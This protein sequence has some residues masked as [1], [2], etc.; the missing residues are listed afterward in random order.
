[1]THHSNWLFLRGLA[2]DKRHWGQ[3]GE[4]FS[5]RINGAKVFMLDLPG[6]GTERHRSAPLT[7]SETKNDLRNRWR[8]LQTQHEGAWNL[9]SLS[10]GGMVAMEWCGSHPYD[11]QKLVLLNTS[12]GRSLWKLPKRLKPGVWKNIIEVAITKS[13]RSKEAC[14]LGINSNHGPQRNPEL[15]E[16]WTQYSS[17]APNSP[18]NNF[19]QIV[20]AMNYNPPEKIHPQTLVVGSMAD[21]MVDVSCSWEL[22]QRYDTQ[23]VLHDTAGHD[24]P[25][26]VPEWLVDHIELWLRGH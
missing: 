23:L 11:F 25:M 9:L 15:Y 16:Q 8:H 5:E 13:P 24:L 22:A 6:M 26:D 3:F 10:L 2:R 17:E 20:A 21:R 7:I 18:V 19:R 14:I 4:I 1:M 12:A